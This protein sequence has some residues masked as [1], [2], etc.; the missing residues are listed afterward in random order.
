MIIS[1]LLE[2]IITSEPW[3]Y[4]LTCPLLISYFVIQNTN[5]QLKLWYRSELS[6]LTSAKF[7]TSV[8]E[9]ARH[10]SQRSAG[11]RPLA[12]SRWPSHPKL[13]GSVNAPHFQRRMLCCQ[14]TA[15]L[16]VW[17]VISTSSECLLYSGFALS[18][19]KLRTL[20]NTWRMRWQRCHS[21]QWF[22]HE[23]TQQACLSTAH[24]RSLALQCWTTHGN[25]G[26]LL[27]STYQTPFREFDLLFFLSSLLALYIFVVH[28]WKCVH[29][30]HSLWSES[31]QMLEGFI[32]SCCKGS[33]NRANCVIPASTWPQDE[34]FFF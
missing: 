14:V 31:S 34:G 29:S 12:H 18:G 15:W 11:C 27:T 25:E 17:P 9:L 1:K 5:V 21:K 20:S 22:R 32:H 2:F 30:Y 4:V 10:G 24:T 6:D 7:A 3:L 26:G 19:L 33:N 16:E 23:I 8:T 13:H 28:P